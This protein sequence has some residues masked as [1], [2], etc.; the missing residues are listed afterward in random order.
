MNAKQGRR[1]EPSRRKRLREVVMGLE[2]VF[3]ALAVVTALCGGM[4]YR[5]FGSRFLMLTPLPWLVALAGLWVVRVG[6]L[7]E[8]WAALKRQLRT[9]G[10]VVLA[11]VLVHVADAL[12]V[13]ARQREP[14]VDWTG[15]VPRLPF[16]PAERELR[17]PGAN[18]ILISIDTLRAD[19]L[20]CYG[21]REDTS[22]HIDRFAEGALRFSRARSSV[23]VTLPSHATMFTSLYPGTHKADVILSIPLAPEVTTLAEVLRDAGY[24]TAAVVD[25]GHMER[26]WKLDQG[27]E[28]YDVFRWEGF[29]TILP[30]A[31]EHLERLKD[32]KFFFFIHTYDVHTP[33]RPTD[34]ELGLFYH[35]Y[36]G[37]LSTPVDNV[38]AQA[39]SHQQM[40]AD[41][42]DIRFVEAAYDG[43]IRWTDA[44]V[45]ILLGRL[46]ELGLDENTIVIITSDHGE[47]FAEHQ[48]VAC[49]GHH[50]WE[51][52]LR[53]PLLVRLP[54]R[55]L[56]GS[57]FDYN[58]G[59]VDLMPSLLYSLTLTYDGPMQGANL[60]PFLDGR[61]G[62]RDLP[63]FAEN[64]C[65]EDRHPDQRAYQR[66]R[67]KFVQEYVTW[68][69]RLSALVGRSKVLY[70]LR[71][72]GLFDT[73]HDYDETRNLLAID[74]RALGAVPVAQWLE[75]RMYE[76]VRQGKRLELPTPEPVELTPE[77]RERLRAMGYIHGPGPEGD[78]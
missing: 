64:Q 42:N 60:F 8:S 22:P 14:Q 27:F 46:E 58:V 30:V 62:P 13:G 29:R 44:Q 1:E 45:G 48:R 40:P 74:Y 9:A 3:L 31:L 59:L 10:A 66:G 21:Y 39:L 70:G 36:Q 12:Y 41:L 53:V 76:L 4:I 71:G 55:A 47:G 16:G 78:K 18:L 43:A 5:C 49:H 56:A 72:R 54:D 52:L 35:G 15:E 57:V 6:L 33:Y 11:V 28:T 26:M 63:T 75:D 69:D 25:G 7:A 24:R 51:E 17:Y 19:H 61:E 73:Y 67:Y 32:E 2:I 37:G 77:E 20:G 68:C 23:G 38:V 34:E 50:L 65:F